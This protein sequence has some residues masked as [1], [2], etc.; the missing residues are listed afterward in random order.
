M[1]SSHSTIHRQPPTLYMAEYDSNSPMFDELL[2]NA[3]QGNRPEYSA[4][5]S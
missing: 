1:C 4:L 5:K 3:V 2:R